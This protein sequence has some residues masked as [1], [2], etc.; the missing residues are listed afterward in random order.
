M[1]RQLHTR[2][3]GSPLP[4]YIADSI[5][6]YQVQKTGAASSAGTEVSANEDAQKSND[7][8]DNADEEGEHDG[9]ETGKL[10]GKQAE[11]DTQSDDDEEDDEEADPSAKL[12]KGSKAGSARSPPVATA[13]DDWAIQSMASRLSRRNLLKDGRGKAVIASAP[14]DAKAVSAVVANV[15][16]SHLAA[17]AT[18]EHTHVAANVTHSKPF[19]NATLQLSAAPKGP[20]ARSPNAS[21]AP[22][23]NL[24]KVRVSNASLIVKEGMVE[25]GDE[26]DEAFLHKLDSQS[27]PFTG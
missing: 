3:A 7:G 20:T 27:L 8:E 6:K 4:K 2:S 23:A 10:N 19:H 21:T 9:E 13:A 17:N 15:T 11:G 26:S 25:T 24:S 16:H 22:A 18:R 5:T 14:T 12:R 1:Q